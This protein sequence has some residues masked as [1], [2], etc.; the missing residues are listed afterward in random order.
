[1]CGAGEE[2]VRGKAWAWLC[3]LNCPPSFPEV[4]CVSEAHGW[5][6]LPTLAAFPNA[7]GWRFAHPALPWGVQVALPALGSNRVRHVPVFAGLSQE[8]L[9]YWIWKSLKQSGRPGC[10]LF[11]SILGLLSP[12]LARAQSWENEGRPKGNRLHGVL[13]SQFWGHQLSDVFTDNTHPKG[14]SP[15]KNKR[16]EITAFFSSPCPLPLLWVLQLWWLSSFSG[17]NSSLLWSS[18]LG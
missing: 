17:S 16:K 18:S 15:S 14:M 5:K 11:M 10:L 12:C 7:R 1:M 3:A 8:N 2:K 13:T 9:S 6:V 4:V